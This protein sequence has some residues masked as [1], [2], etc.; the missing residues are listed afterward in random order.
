MGTLVYVTLSHF[1][2]YYRWVS[3]QS[4]YHFFVPLMYFETRVSCAL[5]KSSCVSLTR[6]GDSQAST[7]ASLQKHKCDITQV[8]YNIDAL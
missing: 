1:H 4:W 5:A 8:R 2:I 3:A 7:E 6:L